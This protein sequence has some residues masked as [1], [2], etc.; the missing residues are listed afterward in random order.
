MPLKSDDFWRTFFAEHPQAFDTP[1]LTVVEALQY[2]HKGETALDLGA[3]AG[4]HAKLLAGNGIHVDAIE[5]VAEL[6]ES[7]NQWGCDRGAALHARQGDITREKFIRKYHLI[8]GTFIWH[9]LSRDDGL[10]LISKCK[11][12][13]LPGGLNAIAAWMDEGDLYHPLNHAHRFFLT[14]GELLKLYID[15][16][17][18]HYEEGMRPTVRRGADGLPQK[19]MTA[20][21]LVQ[22]P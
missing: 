11:D 17:R 1:I 19:N 20:F 16:K 13:T 14:Q 22:K 10:R 5:Q 18:I 4:R 2:L 3:G 9:E 21:L 8:V 7:L 12:A 15:W 6:A